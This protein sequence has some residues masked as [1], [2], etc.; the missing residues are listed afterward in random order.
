MSKFEIRRSL[1][2]TISGILPAIA[3][4][5]GKPLKIG[6]KDADTGINTFVVAA[7]RAD[8]FLTKFSRVGEGATDAELANESLGLG[9]G[10]DGNF[11]RPYVA[12]QPGSIELASEIECEGADYIYGSGTG[13][14]TSATAADTKLS[15]TNGL[16][17]VAQSGDQAQWQLVKQMTP[18]TAGQTRIY[19]KAI[20]GYLV[21]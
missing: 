9:A 16:F 1:P 5:I 19:V 3:L 12:G 11:V 21:P 17:Y 15:F 7:G 6:S 4:P 20:E 8:G 10:E 18:E 2:G 13:Q 14:V